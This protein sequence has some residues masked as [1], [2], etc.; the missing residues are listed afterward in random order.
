MECTSS[1]SGYQSGEDGLHIFT[2]VKATWANFYVTSRAQGS[3]MLRL[4]GKG[5][6][7]GYK[8]LAI[9]ERIVYLYGVLLDQAMV[10]MVSALGLVYLHMIFIALSRE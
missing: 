4:H 5:G 6:V 7:L 8:I 3:W 2:R 1:S 10:S 9:G